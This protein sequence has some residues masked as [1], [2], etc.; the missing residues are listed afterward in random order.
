MIDPQPKGHILK[1]GRKQAPK[2][3]HKC[4]G[5]PPATSVKLGTVWCCGTCG[6]RYKT[7]LWYFPMKLEVPE[8]AKMRWP[9]PRCRNK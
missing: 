1:E 5:L 9:W 8:W 4:S 6:K 7:T 3:P 2:V